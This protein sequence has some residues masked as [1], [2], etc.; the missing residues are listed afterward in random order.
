MTHPSAAPALRRAVT[1]ADRMCLVMRDVVPPYVMQVV[2]SGRGSVDPVALTTAVDRASAA[3]PGARL[4]L[5]GDEWVDSGVAPRV[6]VVRG[7]EL[8]DARLSTDPLL[9]A[10]VGP[11]GRAN[12]EVVLLTGEP[13]VVLFRAFHGVMDGR[14]LVTWVLEVFRVLRG[15]D[16][17]GAADS[18]TARDLVERMAP[19]GRPTVLAPRH[20]SPV[21]HGRPRCG[22]PEYLIRRRTLRTTSPALVARLTAVLADHVEGPA[23]VMVPVDMRRHAPEVRSTANLSLPL[24]LDAEPGTPWPAVNSRLLAGLLGRRELDESG[25]DGLTVLPPVVSR[26]LQRLAYQLGARTGRNLVSA[27]VSHLGR[28]ELGAVRAPGFEPVSVGVLPVHTAMIPVSF[29]MVE[30]GSVT[31]LSVSCRNGRGVGQRLDALLDEISRRLDEPRVT[32]G[33][34]GPADERFA[35]VPGPTR[36]TDALDVRFRR[37]VVATPDAVAVTDPDGSLTYRELADAARAV[38]ARLI[39]CGVAPGDVVGVLAGRT[40]HGVFAQ[41]GVLLAGAAFLPLDPA[42]PAGR[43]AE[44]LRDAG[45]AVCIAERAYVTG[46]IGTADVLVA[47]EASTGPATDPGVARGPGD[48]AYVTYTSGSTGRPKGVEV[49]D[50]GVGTFLDAAVDWYLLGPSSRFA[51]HLTPA[52]DLACLAFFGALLTGG[53]LIVVPEDM[54]H[55]TLRKVLVTS[56]ANTYV[57]TPS[58]VDLTSRLGIVPV[59]PR[60]AVFAGELLTRAVADRARALFG[61][62]ARL[63]NSYGPTEVTIVCATRVIDNEMPNDA[64]SVPIGRSP[65]GTTMLVLDEDLRVVGPGGTGELYFGGP[66][67]AR[68]YRGR[69]DLTAERFV[70][71]PGGMRCYRTGDLVRVLGGGE[72]EFVGRV[73][74]QLKIRGNRVEPTEIRI[75]LERHRSVGSAAVLAVTRPDRGDPA[76]VAYV[77]PARPGE[78]VDAAALRDFLAARVPRFMIPTSFHVLDELPMNANGK[79]DRARLTESVVTDGR[80]AV[81]TPDGD[82]DDRVLRGVRCVW[83]RV[84]GT[85][86]DTLAGGSDFFALGGD[87]LSA[88]RMLAEVSASVVG[89]GSEAEFVE[90]IGRVTHHLTLDRVGAAARTACG[91]DGPACVSEGPGGL[92]S[93][94]P[95]PA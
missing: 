87:S 22:E 59:T 54:S 65:R 48:V 78:E 88:V 71:L 75:V 3:V 41:W 21:G 84:L 91:P 85:E 43:S 7:R 93:R 13:T 74:D 49:T 77:V 27:L 23:R 40:R 4:V 81:R 10:P 15:E 28:V 45:V 5:R 34:I 83:A 46:V 89:V 53:E 39:E 94:G 36:T 6:R 70:R 52:A 25:S 80:A 44:V 42:H 56:G 61:P 58:L 14:G 73:D 63:V 66:Q 35:S 9:G 69:P 1:P 82:G 19:D 76:L 29:A 8:D 38:A 33:P 68:G 60:C 90:Q 95:T 2:V 79:L 20:R 86:E 24:F 30:T 26:V 51:H 55:L 11:A 64:V 17:L 37:Q 31:E 62:Q 57:L 47:E 72:I 67:V 16:P 50:A 12:T 32:P 18:T 92:H